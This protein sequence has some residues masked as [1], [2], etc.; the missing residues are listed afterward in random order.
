MLTLLA[1]HTALAGS[2]VGI[3]GA[4]WVGRRLEE[5]LFEVQA[6]DPVALGGAAV[7]LLAAAAFASWLPA[8]RAGRTDPLHTLK[9]E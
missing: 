7:V 2:I 5:R 1:L 9:A 4:V 8:R 6:A 3:A